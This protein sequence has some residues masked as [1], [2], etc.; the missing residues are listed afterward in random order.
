[1]STNESATFQDTDASFNGNVSVAVGLSQVE[2]WKFKTLELNLEQ[3]T[4]DFRFAIFYNNLDTG[5][6]F[7]DN[8][9]REDYT[10]SKTDFAT[11]E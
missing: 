10:L 6:W 11:I 4:R 9:F 1:M 7:W 2:I 3:S 8:N 5:E